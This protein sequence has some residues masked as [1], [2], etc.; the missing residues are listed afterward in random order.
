MD[1]QVLIQQE[2]QTL[3]N[4]VN[5]LEIILLME[6]CGI[7]KMFPNLTIAF[8]LIEKIRILLKLNNQV[9]IISTIR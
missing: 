1:T 5:S 6:T 4:Q 9:K 2:D 3:N 8:L 7:F